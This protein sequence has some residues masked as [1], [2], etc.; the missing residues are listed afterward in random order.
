MKKLSIIQAIL[1]AIDE[2]D[3]SITKHMNTLIKWSKKCEKSIGSLNGYP[4]KAV[5]ETVSGAS[6]AC[7]D[8]CYRVLSVIMGDYTD[9]LNIRYADIGGVVVHVENISDNDLEYVWGDLSYPRIPKLLWEEVGNIIS[10]AEQYDSQQVTV[11][12]QYIQ[13]DAK[14]YWIVNESHIEAIKKYLIYMISKKFLYRNFRSSKLSRNIDFAI[15]KD[16][17]SDYSTAIRNARA[18]DQQESPLDT[19]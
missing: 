12:Y 3:G 11:V 13:T 7:R 2:T 19:I 15:V 8:D 5:L 14:G 17:K 1:D 4:V 18:E 9:E 6:I 16:Y 10:L